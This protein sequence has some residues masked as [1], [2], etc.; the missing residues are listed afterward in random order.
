VDPGR[1]TDLAKAEMI[2]V[3]SLRNKVPWLGGMTALELTAKVVTW[4]S[5]S[6]PVCKLADEWRKEVRWRWKRNTVGEMW[7]GNDQ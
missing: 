1:S 3:Q 2:S 4:L 7:G 6:V 5:A